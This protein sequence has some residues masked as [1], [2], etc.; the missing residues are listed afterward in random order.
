MKTKSYFEMKHKEVVKELRTW[1]KTL[2][3]I[4]LY[5]FR[6]DKDMQGDGY[7]VTIYYVPRG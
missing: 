6:V 2:S 1:M 4:R 7:R 5:S 3:T